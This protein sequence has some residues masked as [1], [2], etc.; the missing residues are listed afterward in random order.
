MNP[1]NATKGMMGQRKGTFEGKGRN[2]SGFL[3][4][5]MNR[6]DRGSGKDWNISGKQ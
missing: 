1:T 4:Q 5:V 6:R 3:A 2:A